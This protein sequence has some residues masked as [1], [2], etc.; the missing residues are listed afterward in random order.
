MSSSLK[1]VRIAAVCWARTSRS[2]MRC[3]IGLMGT[4]RSA[5]TALAIAAGAGLA[6]GLRAG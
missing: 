1:V 5:S 3:R 6:A 4:T 2:A